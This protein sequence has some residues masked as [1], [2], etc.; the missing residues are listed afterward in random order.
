MLDTDSEEAFDKLARLAG[1]AL[2]MPIALIS[3]VDEARV[4]LKSSIGCQDQAM[5]RQDLFCHYTV[6][7]DD[8]FVVCDAAK[9]TRFAKSSL[10]ESGAVR[11]Y[12]GA[13]IKL[14]DGAKVGAVCVLD[15]L[16]HDDIDRSAFELLTSV[17]ATAA[18]LLELR[19]E[20]MQRRHIE[21][22]LTE[23]TRLLG[24][25]EQVAG[26]G[27]WRMNLATNHVWWSPVLYDIHGIDP[28]AFDPSLQSALD[29]YVAEDRAMIADLVREARTTGKGYTYEA[30]VVRRSDGVLRDVKTTALV[31]F[32][33]QGAP[34]FLIG[35]FRDIME[36]KSALATLVAARR[37][38]DL[39]S[40][41]M[42]RLATT[43]VLTSLPNRRAMIEAAEEKIAATGT[44][45]LTLTVLDIDHFKSI[46]DGFGH[47]VGDNVLKEFARRCAE[48]L[49]SSYPIGRIGGEEF[50]VLMSG[51]DLGKAADLIEN[52]R[53]AV[54]AEPMSLPG[55]RTLPVTFSAGLAQAISG[56]DWRM[57]FSRADKALYR[58]KAEGRDRFSLAA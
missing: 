46:N 39:F 40:A 13:P 51:I 20:L 12:A 7:Q 50:V 8:V 45:P 16:P 27:H 15:A 29:F 31:E 6:A 3:L 14:Q 53:R 19:R 42:H 48:A 26:V 41:R 36:E 57:L 54:I 25:A 28:H 17:A 30:R 11:F 55:G 38:A 5:I 52:V 37:E 1:D 33:E 21:A 43:D 35:M 2:K 22:Q 32:N 34:K 24:L 9:D 47:E 4:W 23:H 49:G 44:E 56:D 18:H 10:V 58:A